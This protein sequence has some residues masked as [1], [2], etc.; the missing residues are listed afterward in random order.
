M[1]AFR[2]R[3][4]ASPLHLLGHVAAIAAAVFAV[5][6][7]LDPRFSHPV[8]YFAWLLLGAAL[9][10]LLL[11]PLYSVLDAGARLLVGERAVNY[12]RFPVVV[13]A[14]L[15][16]VYFPLIVGNGRENYV[17]ASGHAPPDYLGRWLAITA[18]LLVVSA[19]LAVV[20]RGRSPA[21]SP[22]SGP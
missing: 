11:L 6:Q 1:S 4:G 3:Y 7:V 17:R 18:G 16:L 14:V 13:S 5:A 19:L 9:H 22:T 2:R 15:F 12:V 8:N 20:R 10:D 21:P